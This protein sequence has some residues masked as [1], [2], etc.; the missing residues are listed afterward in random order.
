MSKVPVVDIDFAPAAVDVIKMDGGGFILKS[1][2]KLE[3]YPP[4][5]GGSLRR[6]ADATPERLFLA[7]RKADG[8]WRKIT[9][10]DFL[11]RVERI[12]QALL[13]R[14]LDKE[15]P[16]MILSD[17]G[18]DNA[19]LLHACMYVGI[20]VVPVSPAYSLMSQDH[21][22]LKHIFSQIL[23]ELIFTA[24]GE[25]FAKAMAAL[26][27]DGVEVV[28]SAAPPDGMSCTFFDDLDAAP[29]DAV[30]E[31]FNA[32]GPDTLAKILYTSGSTGMPKGVK[33]TQRMMCSNQQAITQLWPF[34]KAKPPIIVDWL[35][36]NHT[37]G[38]NHNFN[39]VLFNGGTLYIDGGKPAPGLIEKTVAI[40]GEIS[41]TMYFNVPRGFDVLLPFLEADDALRDKFFKDLDVIFYAAAALPQSLWER[42]EK[43]S[44]ASRGKMVRMLSAWGS[45]ETAPLATS[46]HFPIDRAGVIGLPAPGT[47]LKMVPNGSKLEMRVRGP[48]VTPGY[49]KADDLTQAA[50]DEDGFY[51]IGDAGRLADPSDPAKG[52]VF[53]GRTA[54]DFKLLSG[55]W[56]SAGTLRIA[57]IAACAPVVQDAVVTGH[58]RDEV[59][60]LIFPNP[61]G[62]ESVGDA[63][64]VRDHIRRGLA[65]HNAENPAGS[66]RI[67]RVILLTQPPS[68][69]ANEITDKGYI[70]QR[71]VLECRSEQL[72]ELYSSNGNDAVILMDKPEPT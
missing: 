26:P 69:D 62:C 3:E 9:Y 46:V 52:I 7:E 10:G 43:L 18:V 42:L 1:P 71:A 21:G 19:L 31:S 15:R 5:L 48:N 40:L 41:S 32:V 45:T 16:V 6:W 17:N 55:T 33:N 20:P 58:D 53:D 36:W 23:P 49:W 54:E 39:M 30:S 68:I 4:N 12:A 38:G 44:I 25:M 51:C 72:N 47:E 65:R 57:A 14:N 37:F 50:F 67:S 24:N 8:S 63:A 13:D 64:K 28:V 34:V 35:P 56:V 59:G 11:S 61:G 66:T 22:K 70:N 27:M 29:T 60:L 2:M